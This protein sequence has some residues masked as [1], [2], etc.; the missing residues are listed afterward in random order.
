MSLQNQL[1]Q[2]HSD[3]AEAARRN[4]PQSRPA[5]APVRTATPKPSTPTPSQPE[6]RSHDVA[7][8]AEVGAGKGILDRVQL[9]IE[10]AKKR[11]PETLS[12]DTIISYLSLPNELEQKKHL[13][14][15]A[16][17]NHPRI[18]YAPSAESQKAIAVGSTPSEKAKAKDLFRY[19]PLHPVTNGEELREYLSKQETAAGISV[20][21]L[22]DGWPDCASTI[23]ALESQGHLLVL[24]NK[25]DNTARTLWLDNPS[26]HITKPSSHPPIVKQ[27][28]LD[29]LERW[30]KIKLPAN[31]MDIRNELERAGLTPTSAVKE[32]RTQVAKKK[33]R[34]R[35]ERKNGKKTNTHLIGVLKD[36]S[37]MKK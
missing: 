3:R 28:D 20:K 1:N 32:I 18:A 26:F 15:R 23:D 30:M 12:F 25:K 17:T 29:F 24:R 35:V 37:K 4:L 22:K 2:F 34:K 6:K 27:A 10:Y 21:E 33:E 13:F 8:P 36:F 19:R 11:S 5:A 9:A 14:H 7:F 31:E 16:L